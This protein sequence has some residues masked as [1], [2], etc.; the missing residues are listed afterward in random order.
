MTTR[1]IL[2]QDRDRLYGQLVEAKD[3][4]RAIR[5]C[6]DE[7]DRI[8]MRHNERAE[9]EQ[10]SEAAASLMQTARSAL[11]MMDSGGAPQVYQSSGGA[12]AAGRWQPM[13]GAGA[14]GMLAGGL[15]IALI[16]SAV[17]AGLALLAAGGAAL[18]FAGR[19]MG[20]GSPRAAAGRQIV[21]I[22]VDADK[23]WHHLVMITTVVDQ[24]LQT[25]ALLPPAEAPALSAAGSGEAGDSELKLLSGLLETAYARAD[26][27]DMADVASEIRFYLHGKGVET[28][29]YSP[30]NARWFTRMPSKRAGTLRPALVKDGEVLVKGMAAG[31]DR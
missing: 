8:V 4:D 2:E 28:V 20:G 3:M 27:P 18:F 31:G 26:D 19:A 29:D 11:V 6:E 24:N 10:T 30:E 5:V 12:P 13:L 14:G 17:A 22:P 21:E 25:G 1:E 15:L 9:N 7:L 16:P 23:I